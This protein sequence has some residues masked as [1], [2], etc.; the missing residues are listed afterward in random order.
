MKRLSVVYVVCVVLLLVGLAFA[1]CAAKAPEQPAQPTTPTEPIKI[2][3][4][5]YAPDVSPVVF[6]MAKPWIETIEKRTNGKVQFSLFTGGSLTTML[7]GYEQ[8][9][10]GVTD[11]FQYAPNP[12]FFFA[13]M[14]HLPCHFGSAEETAAVATEMA[15]KYFRAVDYPDMKVLALWSIPPNV[16]ISATGKLGR[17][18]KTMDDMKGLRAPAPGSATYD[19]AYKQLGIVGVPLPPTAFYEAFEKGM[20]DISILNKDANFTFKIYMATKYRTLMPAGLFAYSMGFFMNQKVFDSLPP[21]VQR[22]I[23]EES[24]MKFSI[25][26]AKAMVQADAAR[27][28]EIQEYDKKSGNPE[29][30]Y[31]SQAEYDRIRVAM[32]PVVEWWIAQR[33]AKGLP[34]RKAYSE[35]L[36]LIK[37]YRA[38]YPLQ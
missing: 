6:A 22:V 5:T 37:K 21:D 14:V 36:E 38:Q 1:G 23:N 13:D 2:R 15:A 11:I 35:M 20:L 27:W 18:I 16:L 31:M 4:S 30:C 7:D 8:C 3:F 9:Q 19:E 24:G 34:A 26:C 29:C 28:A 32:E 12:R 33:E 25:F 10:K 17:C